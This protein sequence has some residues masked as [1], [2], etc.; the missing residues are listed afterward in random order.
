[1]SECCRMHA[2]G[3]GGVYLGHSIGYDALDQFK[4]MDFLTELLTIAAVAYHSFKGLLGD[5]QPGPGDTIS[6][7]IQCRIYDIVKTATLTT[8][9]ILRWYG[10]V[11]Q[12][13]LGD[14]AGLCRH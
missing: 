9:E 10:N 2:Q 1:M 5:G 13:N 7:V 11:V 6:A 3:A 14:M 12:I 8:Q 4:L